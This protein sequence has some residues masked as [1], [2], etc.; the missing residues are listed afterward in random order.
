MDESESLSHTRCSYQSAAGKR[1]CMGSFGR[2]LGDI[3]RKL[4]QQ[5]E[6]RVEEGHLMLDH[7]HMM[8]SVPPK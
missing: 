4:A 7:V 8:L 5:K 6:S 1:R 2:T 3:F